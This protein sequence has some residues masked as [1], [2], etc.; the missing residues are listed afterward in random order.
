MKLL[1][2]ISTFRIPVM[3]SSTHVLAIYNQNGNPK[4]V[5]KYEKKNGPVKKVLKK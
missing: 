4:H 3:S 5:A 1:I 2:A